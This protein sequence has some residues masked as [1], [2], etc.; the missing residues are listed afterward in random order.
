MRQK[1]HFSLE[2][3]DGNQRIICCFAC[4]VTCKKEE[5]KMNHKKTD[6]QVKTL[7]IKDSKVSNEM[8]KTSFCKEEKLKKP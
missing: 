6:T 3:V 4:E 1:K 8:I 5:S 2:S 7:E